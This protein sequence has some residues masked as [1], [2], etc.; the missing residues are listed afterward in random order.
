[1]VFYS[2]KYTYENVAEADGGGGIPNAESRREK[3]ASNSSSSTAS[4]DIK[5][6]V[7]YYNQVVDNIETCKADIISTSSGYVEA[8]ALCLKNDV[9]P[10]Y[11]QAD[12]DVEDM[13]RL[14][15]EETDAVIKTMRKVRDDYIAVD[16]AK[17]EDG[18]DIY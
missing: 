18:A 12:H 4:G 6:D 8:D 11:Q 10:D 7:D 2:K 13:L 15:Q 1:M 14:F 9:I 17:T 5:M 16:D 3:A